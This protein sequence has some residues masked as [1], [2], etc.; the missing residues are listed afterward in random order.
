[1]VAARLFERR[2]AGE[3]LS[4]DVIGELVGPRRPEKAADMKD[5]PPPPRRAAILEVLR[6]AIASDEPATRYAAAQVLAVRNQPATFW[7]EAARLAGPAR[8]GAPAPNTGYAPEARVARKPGWLRRLV[9][10]EKRDPDA[11]ELEELAR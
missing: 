2:A 5:W 11:S 8:G 9:T 6:N 4:A 1:F 7:R 3:P 10:A